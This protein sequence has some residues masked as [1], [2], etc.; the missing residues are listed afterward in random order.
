M[1]I[2]QGASLNGFVPFPTADPWNEAI[3]SLPVN[4]GSAAVMS[5]FGSSTLH[6]D[7]GSGTYDGAK[8]GIPYQVVSGQ[9]LVVVDP[10]EY[11]S[12]SDPGPMP[13]PANAP[14]EGAGLPSGT[15]TDGHVLI[16]DQSNCFLY[17]LFQGALQGDGSWKASSTAIWDLL[18]DNARPFNWTSADAAGL[19]IFPG[20][21]RYDEVASGVIKHAIRFTLAYTAGSFVLPATHETSGSSGTG[22]PPFGARFRLKSTFNISGFSEANQ[23]ILQAMKTYG[24]ILADNGSNMYISGTPDSRW[25]NSDLSKLGSVTMS[26][27]DMVTTGTIYTPTSVPTT[28]KP[29]INSMTGMTVTP[30]KTTATSPSGVKTAMMINS[31]AMVSSGATVAPGTAVT[32]EWSASNASYYV[33][34]PGVGAVRGTAATVTPTQTTTYTLYANSH[35]GSVTKTFTINV[36]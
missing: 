35:T 24:I 20:L 17:E 32:L 23:V 7:F 15:Y 6:P 26:D 34:T 27:F 31:V 21:V 8:I 22:R 5:V 25:N 36:Q 3:T 30:L 9:P 29:V 14:V 33:L 19:P 1:G 11:A 28:P 16:L 4:S 12:Q 18:A 13:I 2:G 10:T